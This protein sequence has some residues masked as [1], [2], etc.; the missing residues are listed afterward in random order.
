MRQRYVRRDSALGIQFPEHQRIVSFGERKRGQRLTAGQAMA[1]DIT[2]T[3]SNRVAGQIA[4][5]IGKSLGGA[6]GSQVG[7]AIIRGALG[8]MLKR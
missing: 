7:R 8:G 5:D 2:R 4:A 3:V 6:T 1:R